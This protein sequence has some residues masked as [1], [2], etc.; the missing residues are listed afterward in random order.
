MNFFTQTW[1]R[2]SAYVFSGIRLLTPESFRFNQANKRKIIMRINFTFTVLITALLQISLAADAQKVTFS[3]GNA[4][5]EEV[6]QAIH[7]QTGYNFLYTDEMMGETEP[8]DAQF[9]NASL[10]EALQQCFAGQLLTYTIN[11]KAVVIRRR[12]QLMEIELPPVIV[13]G[14]VT[15]NTGPLP[16]VSIKLKGSSTGTTTDTEGRYTINIPD[17]IGTL[18]FSFIG[19]TAQEIIVAGRNTIDVKLSAESGAL[20]EVVVVGYGTQKR[21][22]LTGAISTVTGA[23]L[24][25][26]TPTNTALALQGMTPG[27]TILN[28][29]GEPG[30]GAIGVRIRGVGTLGNS[31][32]LVLIDGIE[33]SLATIEPASIESLTILKDA[34]SAAIY[35]S[36]AA[37][38]V[39]LITTK[40]GVAN[41]ISVSYNNQL[42]FQ[43]MTSFPEKADPV[44]WLRLENE[45]QVN[46]GGTPSFSETYIQNVAAGTN[47]LQYPFANWEEGIFNPNAPEQRH[48]LTV[49]SGGEFGKTFASVDY[50]NT[51]GILQNFNN[52]Q[53]TM[54]LNSDLYVSKKLTLKTNLMYRNGNFSGPGFNGQQLIQSLLHINRNMVMEYPDG[55]YDLLGG[56]WNARAMVSHGESS[57]NKN[58]MV[59]LMGFTYAINKVLSLEGNVAINS[60]GT[61]EFLFRDGLAGMR[62]YV[63]G[64]PVPVGSWFA[65]SALTETQ[66]NRR[67]LSQRAFLNY[68]DNFDKHKVQAMAG[69][70]EIG[71]RFKQV[72]ASRDN[73]FTNQLRD[74][75][76]GNIKNQ[77]TGGFIEEWRLRSF[78][79]RVN[80]SFDDKYLFQANVRYDGSSRFGEGHRWGLFPSFS[81]GW[82]ISEEKFLKDSKM[83]NT[84]KIRGSWGQLGNQNIGLYRFLNT[85]NLAQ[86]YQ[87]DNSVVQGAAVTAA[88]NP[89][90]TWETSTMTNIGLDM[91]FLDNR[92]EVVAEY[93]WKY[94]DDILL[95]LPIPLTIGVNAPLQ[96][97]AVVSNIGW[98]V[99]V[100][101]RGAPRTDNGFQYSVGV[102]FSNVINKIEDLKGAGPF[103]PDKFS[104]WTVGESINSLRGLKSPGLYR[105][106]DDLKKYPAT[107]NPKV[108]IGD[109]IYEDLNGDGVISQSL[110]P[111]GD[112][113]I[114]ANEDPKYEFGIRSNASYRGFDLAMFWQGVLNQQHT[115]DGALIEGPNWNNFIPAEM[116]R[117]T[118]HPTRNPNGSWPLVTSGNTWNLNLSDFW[119][120]DTKYIRLKNLQIGYTVPQKLISS[121][122]VYV[123]GE[124]ILTFTPTKLF[125]P[126]TPRGRSQFFPHTR[127]ISA[128]VNVRF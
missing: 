68:N 116:A 98:E 19:F 36:R 9:K 21:A 10:E 18:V 11:K 107:L 47:P 111:R 16:G 102:N 28:G 77:T 31:N 27:L 44:S 97:A 117:E 70:E 45:A 54:R 38:G 90:I 101:Y 49:S 126:E 119:L 62:N 127:I 105:T 91:G 65:T 92:L 6:L 20:D 12:P 51:D 40:R 37:N 106:Q 128:G 29:G 88:G 103:F 2:L 75:S 56:Q 61:D 94:T 17:G 43:N 73:F 124:N 86:G 52:K 57:R 71:N 113:Y 108:T 83:I 66:V 60:E 25:K 79:S 122:R 7:K 26:R 39:I 72:S 78:F 110:F 100:N 48:S 3:K 120:Q 32:P 96:N 22:D 121:L 118:Y 59:G 15:D 34:A 30:K 125:D 85:Y 63:T 50:I 42:G 13:T 82:R 99:A 53:I 112:Q 84:L 89:T 95:N 4:S 87:F 67:E 64:L 58:D 55:T 74:L 93:F 115:M 8:V 23:D 114:M 14:K 81:A 33:Q 5:L 69:Y 76:A 1:P 35:G 123:A 24:A 109:I 104:V 41:G 46:A 80:Y